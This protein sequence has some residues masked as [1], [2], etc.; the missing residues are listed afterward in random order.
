MQWTTRPGKAQLCPT[1]SRSFPRGT[2]S[3][4]RELPGVSPSDFPW[5]P[6]S[7]H[8]WLTFRESCDSLYPHEF[9]LS[10]LPMKYIQTG[11]QNSDPVFCMHAGRLLSKRAF[12]PERWT[13]C[14]RGPWLGPL[15]QEVLHRRPGQARALRSPDRRVCLLWQEMGEAQLEIITQTFCAV[16]E[17]SSDSTK[18]LVS[19]CELRLSGLPKNEQ[20]RKGWLSLGSPCLIKMPAQG[21]PG[22]SKGPERRLGRGQVRT[23]GRLRGSAV[24]PRTLAVQTCVQGTVPCA[25]Y[26]RG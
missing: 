12:C 19:C 10:K 1:A 5:P 20:E 2:T 3:V 22:H 7:V 14:D 23:G 8:S 15:V 25:G 18:L 16:K 4:I 17:M 24:L 11:V 21:L 13:C 6:T 9:L 26:T